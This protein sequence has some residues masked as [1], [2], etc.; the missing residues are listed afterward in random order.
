MMSAIDLEKLKL[1]TDSLKKLKDEILK[2]MDFA[3]VGAHLYGRMP[4]GDQTKRLIAAIENKYSRILA[5]PTG[6]MINKRGPM[7]FNMEKV[8]DACVAN[9]VALEVNSNPQRI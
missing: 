8:I 9:K 4:K 1:N 3:I 5:H 2:E 6:R 7:E